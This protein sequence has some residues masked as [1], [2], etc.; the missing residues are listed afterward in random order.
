METTISDNPSSASYSHV[1][2]RPVDI[3]DINIDYSLPREERIR[4]YLQQIK[5]PY[6]FE[7]K[8][9][10]VNIAKTVDPLKTALKNISAGD[11]GSIAFVTMKI[12]MR[13]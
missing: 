7:H 5:D 8:G 4:A 1:G 2:Y 9:V 12:I 10:V 13:R 6:K 3:T 11:S